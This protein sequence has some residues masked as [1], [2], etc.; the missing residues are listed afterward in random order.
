MKYHRLFTELELGGYIAR[1][2]LEIEIYLV[3]VTAFEQYLLTHG[4]ESDGLYGH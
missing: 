3:R 2:L 1:G 4:E